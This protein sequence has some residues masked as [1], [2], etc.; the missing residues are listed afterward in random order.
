M[1]ADNISTTTGLTG[2]VQ[3]YFK[4]AW[5]DLPMEEF[6][7]PLVNSPLAEPATIPNNAG[8][9]AEFRKFDHFTPDGTLHGETSEPTGE[10]L[11]SET[12]QA[13]IEE[14][15][16]SISLGH[17]LT[18]TDAIN[19]TQKAITLMRDFVP[20]NAHI[21]V[22][23]RF[24]NTS[25]ISN[26]G[27]S[28]TNT[29][30]TT[31]FAGGANSFADVVAG[32]TVRMSDFKRARSAMENS[33]VPKINGMYAAI[34]DDATK[35]Q[36]LEDD[37]KFVRVLERSPNGGDRDKVFGMANLVDFEGIR[38]FL[39]DDAY[40]TALASESGALATRVAT[41]KVH[42]SHVVGAHA[43]GQVMLGSRGMEPRF[44][45]Q[46]I[47]V[48]G[49]EKT[50]GFRIPFQSIVLDNEWGVNVAGTTNYSENVASL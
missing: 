27:L 25:V 9:E 1:A 14:I 36:L 22:T 46:D 44:K 37:E 34:I 49:I 2:V 4:R 28:R 42:V 16:N 15:S 23:D 38:W 41:G 45:V 43:F 18:K 48:T 31:T 20:R 7:S 10:T 32:S 26:F 50:L 11:S 30:F 19:I 6:R 29:A 5:M 40:R 12:T 21:A 33:N 39:Q 13:P 24:V 35:N 17:L 3:N 47:T 8:Q